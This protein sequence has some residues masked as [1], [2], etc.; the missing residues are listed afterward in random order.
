M[1]EKL[2]TLVKG[3]DINVRER[4]KNQYYLATY[5]D[6]VDTDRGQTNLLVVE[7]Y[8]IRGEAHYLFC[9]WYFDKSDLDNII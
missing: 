3:K 2:T 9:F 6:V 7:K 1:S 5:A 8:L 4:I